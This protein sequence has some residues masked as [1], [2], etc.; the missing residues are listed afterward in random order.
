MV[1][2]FYRYVAGIRTEEVYE[3][4]D[5]YCVEEVKN[6]FLSHFSPNRRDDVRKRMTIL[7]TDDFIYISCTCGGEI[8]FIR[9]NHD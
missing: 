7:S 2:R 5:L 3:I 6:K 9:L 8:C 4:I 1:S